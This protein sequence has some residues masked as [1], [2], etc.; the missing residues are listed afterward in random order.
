[1][2]TRHC[3]TRR[4]AWPA[5]RPR[6]CS[7]RGATGGARG[8]RARPRGGARDPPVT[9][10]E[11]RAL[12]DAWEDLPPWPEAAEVLE[13]VRRRGFGLA[14]LSNGDEGRLRRLGGAT[15]PVPVGQVVSTEGGR[16]KPHPS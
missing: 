3:T 10:D 6:Y 11:L 13:E 14:T 7:A 16:F 12:V 8:P 2:S 15:P 5:R 4:P 1:M 9:P